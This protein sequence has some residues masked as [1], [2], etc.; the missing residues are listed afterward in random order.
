MA[1]KK[2]KQ[3]EAVKLSTFAKK[4]QRWY[5]SFRNATMVKNAVV[6]GKITQAEC[7]TILG[8]DTE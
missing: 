8:E 7:N 2:S 6:K 4:V 5:E 1:A 3:T